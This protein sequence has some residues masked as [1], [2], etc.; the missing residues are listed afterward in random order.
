MNSKEKEY[1]NNNM[2]SNLKITIKKIVIL[3]I[4]IISILYIY[5][6][7]NFYFTSKTVFASEIQQNY[8][9]ESIDNSIDNITEIESTDIENTNQI[10][11]EKFIEEE[12]L[13]EYT[14]T[15]IESNELPKDTIQVIQEGREGI[16][17]ITTKKYYENDLLVKEEQVSSKIIKAPLNK[18]VKIG[19][20]SN[21]IVSEIK[22]GDIV[23]PTSN[24]LELKIEPNTS[25]QK[26]TILQQTEKLKI[27][28]SVDEWYKV[29]VDNMI[30]YVKKESVTTDFAI[31]E[32]KNNDNQNLNNSVDTNINFNIDL[33]KPSGLSLEQF[34][35]VL[36]DGKDTN[37]VFEENSEYFYY[38]E[39]QYNINGIFVASVAIHES[40]WG[41]SQISQEKNNLFGYGAYDNNAYKS[42]YDF[43]T[44]SEGID[45]ISRVFVKYYLNPKGTKI[46]SG[47][48]S[49]GRYYNGSTLSD[50]N[51]CYA[52]DDN[53]AEAVYN[54]MKYLY[55]K[56]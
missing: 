21:M 25:S 32:E 28:D 41:T 18:I 29:E 20:N 19:T 12:N 26:L 22:T 38:I 45:L 50:V 52:T 33:R 30:G 44:Y 7:Y 9:V 17:K 46:Y 4:V 49:D 37:Q 10:Y 51:K 35:K 27:I 14:T 13:L 16:Q 55:N 39:K 2:K 48:I 5:I 43:R 31:Q 53:W 56:L 40:N 24:R 23:Y 11:K 54:H 34:K 47:E 36:K 1:K 15:Y 3:I 42:A 6:F 8:N